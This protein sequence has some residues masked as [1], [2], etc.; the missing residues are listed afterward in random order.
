[1]DTDISNIKIFF[2]LCVLEAVSIEDNIIFGR[3]ECINSYFPCRRNTRRN[4]I[5]NR[6]S[7]AQNRK[8]RHGLSHGPEAAL[9]LP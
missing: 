4:V 6:D 7:R 5:A 1:M 9:G 2:D 8:L 3:G